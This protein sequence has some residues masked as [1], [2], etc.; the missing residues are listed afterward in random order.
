ML[1]EH[2]KTQTY[3]DGIP[4]F[5][6]FMETHHLLEV[7]EQSVTRGCVRE[8]CNRRSARPRNDRREEDP[9]EYG[10]TDAVHHEQKS[11]DPE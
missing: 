9:N 7:V 3:V 11:E 6:Q 4:D 5:L 8:I 1:K 2:T 10:A